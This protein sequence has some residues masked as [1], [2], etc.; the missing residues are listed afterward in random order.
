[1]RHS[2]TETTP[3]V[4]SMEEYLEKRQEKRRM[5]NRRKTRKDEKT[6]KATEWSAAFALC[7]LY[8]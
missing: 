5:E 6:N 8:V 2:T 1:M 7:E 3:E 4:L